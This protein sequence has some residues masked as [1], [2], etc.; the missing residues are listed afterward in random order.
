MKAEEYFG[1]DGLLSRAFDG[2]E[3]RE[4][5]EEM[6]QIVGDAMTSR[7]RVIIEAG[8]GTGKTLAYLIPAAVT[9]CRT[10]VS[11]ATKALQGQIINKDVPAVHAAGLKLTAS[12]L[13]GRDNYICKRKYRHAQS[14]PPPWAK[15]NEALWKKLQVWVRDDSGFRDRATFSFVGEDG[16]EWQD[17]TCSGQNCWRK[18]C[19]SQESCYAD[20]ARAVAISSQV[21][22]VNHHLFFADLALKAKGAPGILPDIDFVVLDEAHRL[23]DAA[24]GFFSLSASHARVKRF[25]GAIDKL[26]KHYPHDL[27]KAIGLLHTASKRFFTELSSA[28]S[29]R[30]GQQGSIEW[31]E[32]AG[33]MED[34]NLLA[35]EQFE[36]VHKKLGLLCDDDIKTATH[37]LSAKKVVSAMRER[38]QRVQGEWIQIIDDDVDDADYVRYSKGSKYGARLIASPVC[39]GDILQRVMLPIYQGM[40]LVSATLAVGDSFGYFRSRVGLMDP[41][42]ASEAVVDSP[43]D[44][45]M[46][47]A[48]YVPAEFPMPNDYSFVEAA[49]E[50]VKE[51]VAITDNRAFVLC[52]S[53]KNMNGIY[54]GLKDEL[55]YQLLVQGSKSKDE[56]IRRFQRKPSVLFATS[57]FWEGVDIPGDALSLVVIDKIPFMAYKDPLIQ[58]RVDKIKEDGG[59]PFMDYQVPTAALTLKQGFG[60]LIRRRTDRGI[61]ALLDIRMVKGRYASQLWDALPL[62]A[63]CETIEQLEGWYH[64]PEEWEE[65][66]LEED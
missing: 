60:R 48:T 59:N 15:K 6:A 29:D 34:L 61:V 54:N 46:Q 52:T 63:D 30:A 16:Q 35:L 8:T 39:P 13:K 64:N 1:P 27:K 36:D 55:P 42:C 40:A 51:L 22:I 43:F 25:I 2:Y 45:E 32:L 17:L 37:P 4:G 23:E 10:I 26:V 24:T 31:S 66:L 14:H 21:L 65:R 57:S 56:L 58:A 5:Q 9:G 7:S 47:A 18:R 50:A 3:Y 28:T 49:C 20:T 53:Y 33:D 11:T 38:S 41:D 44:Y 62:C 12:V 19:P